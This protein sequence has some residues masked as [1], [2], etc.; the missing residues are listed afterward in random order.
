MPLAV[1][2]SVYWYDYGLIIG[3]ELSGSRPALIIS[4]TELNRALS[5]AVAI[6]M[7]TTAPSEK[8]LRN[9]AFV[10]A[11]G[12]WASARQIQAVDQRRLGAKIAEAA[13]HELER[14]LEILV[15]RLASRINRPGIIQTE[16]GDEQIGPGTIWEVEFRAPDG[17]V[18][19]TQVLVLDYNDGNKMAIAV[20]V[21]H[22]LTPNSPV[23]IPINITGASQPASALVHRVRS[24]DVEARTATKTGVSD[25]ASFVSVRH[26][27]LSVIVQ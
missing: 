2:G 7:S 8:H 20:E 5:I 16:S 1:R 17:S 14:I 19:P 25:A 3:N 21:E 27:L 26:A 18:L 24:I 4:N 6:P 12:S 11:A 15:A 13:A 23:R 10:E 22:R 9:H